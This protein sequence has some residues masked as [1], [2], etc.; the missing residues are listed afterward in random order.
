M[1]IWAD[2]FIL[3]ILSLFVLTTFLSHTLTWLSLL[4]RK[5]HTLPEDFPPIPIIKPVRG[6]DQEAEENFL[7]F[8]HSGY[9]APFEVIFC[10]EDRDDPVVPVIQRLIASTQHLGNVHLIFSK[11]QDQREIGK[12]INLMAGI[13]ESS[14]EVLVLS[15]S[16]VRNTPGFLEELVTPLSK[17]RTGLVYAC[18][19]YKGARDWVA[20]LMA[21]SVNETILAL[22]SAPQFAAIGSAMA[23]RKDV[24]RA[25]G[26]LS[27]MRHRVGI[28][29]A[30]SRAVRAK[31][32]KI[33]LIKQPV[34]IIHQSSTFMAWWRQIHRWLVTIRIYLGPRYLIILLYG[35]PISWATLYLFLSIYKERG[36]QGVALWGLILGVRLVS[37]TLVNLFFVKE[38]ALWRYLWLTPILDF[39]RV[40]LWLEAY[41]NPYVVWRGRRYRVMPDATVRPVS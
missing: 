31:G 34:T 14:Y 38:P 26:G 12:T 24:L 30:L 39:L 15:D 40:P 6:F 28:D 23:I 10:V 7:S 3:I 4:K 41:I 2:T 32:Y 29:A 20:G 18:P 1:P 9:P 25:I 22:R 19:V 35:F 5:A 37:L 27:P 36:L 16:D 13:K 33:E 11:R 17:P 8:I 21:L